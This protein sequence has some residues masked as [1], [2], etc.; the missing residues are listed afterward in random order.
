M[1]VKVWEEVG[2]GA[3]VSLINGLIN[4]RSRT[5]FSSEVWARGWMDAVVAMVAG[6]NLIIRARG[7]G[8]G[9][10]LLVQSHKLYS[11]AFVTQYRGGKG[12]TLFTVY[13]F[14]GTEYISRMSR[15]LKKITSWFKN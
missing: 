8:E 11:P 9:A 2:G 3:V 15:G 12:D 13:R 1:T 7:G 5:A 4:S 6:P 14:S 10:Y